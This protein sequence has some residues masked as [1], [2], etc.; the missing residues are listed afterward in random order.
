MDDFIWHWTKGNTK[1]FTRDST[2][3]EKAMRNGM[4][5]IGKKLRPRIMRY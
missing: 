5:V 4:L 1:V 3:A 2:V